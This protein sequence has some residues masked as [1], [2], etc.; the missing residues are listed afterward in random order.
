MDNSTRSMAISA[1]AEDPL[2]IVLVDDASDLRELVRRRLEVTGGFTVAAEGATGHDAIR[3]A[4]EHQPDLVLL[5]VSM[6]ETD[7]LE[8]IAGVLP[9]CPGTRVGMFSGC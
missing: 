1:P 8:A 7:G 9:P 2:T 5:D 4:A 3:L 6:C